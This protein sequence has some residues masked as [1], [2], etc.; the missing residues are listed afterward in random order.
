[1]ETFL[2]RLDAW[3]WYSKIGSEGVYMQIDIDRKDCTACS[4]CWSDCPEIFEEDPKDGLSRIVEKYRI[5]DD[6]A[7][8]N[9]PEELSSVA[10]SAADNCPVSVIH[11]Q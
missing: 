10:Q 7:R 11:V 4:L 2:R 1:M 3:S 9:V 6:I 8:G 5:A